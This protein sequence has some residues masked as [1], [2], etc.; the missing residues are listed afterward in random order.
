MVLMHTNTTPFQYVSFH[1]S[2]A[3]NAY[4]AQM[5]MDSVGISCSSPSRSSL[6][7]SLLTMTTPAMAGS[8][9]LGGQGQQPHILRKGANRKKNTTKGDSSVYV[10]IYTLCYIL[11]IYLTRPICIL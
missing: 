8:T 4:Y 11:Q 5:Q 7:S 9:A 1:H 2:A 10:S 6:A 3:L